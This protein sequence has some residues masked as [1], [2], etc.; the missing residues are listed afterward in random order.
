MAVV[1]AIVIC[2]APVE[3][4]TVVAVLPPAVASICGEEWGFIKALRAG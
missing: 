3:L 2:V 4:V 1:V